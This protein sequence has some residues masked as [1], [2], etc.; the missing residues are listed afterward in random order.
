MADLDAEQFQQVDKVRQQLL[1]VI[2]R[3]GYRQVDTPIVEPT[4]LF[5]RK[6]GGERVAQMYAFHYRE[7][8]IALRPEHTAS[9]LRM[10]VDSMQSQPLPLRLCYAGPVFRYEKPQASRTRQ[11][12][13][14]GCELLGASGP[15]ADAEVIHL[16]LDGLASVGVSGVLVLGHVGL[17]LE[18]LERLPLRHRARDWLLWSMERLRKGRPVDLET[19]IA[20]LTSGDRLA[21]LFD[22]MS[23]ALGQ[24]PSEQLEG[25]VLAVLNEVGVQT[26]GGSRTPQEIVAGVVDKMNSH[27]DEGHVRQAFEFV[28]QLAGLRGAPEYV[29]PELRALVRAHDL[30]EEPIERI[31]QVLEI[32]AIYGH[33]TSQIELSPGL[34]RGLHYYTGMLFEIYADGS[35]QVQLCGGGRYDDLAQTLGSRQPLEASGFTYGLER[36]AEVAELPDAPHTARTL[37]VPA[38]DRAHASAIRAAE[39]MRARGEVVELDVRGRSVAAS[40]RFAQRN[41]INALLVVDHDGKSILERFDD[42]EHSETVRTVIDG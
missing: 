6:S 27:S 37:V 3:H 4:E 17:V 19:E 20:G 1:N 7:R 42:V 5:L 8:D 32:L 25:W 26:E 15:L 24:V 40:R 35:Q 12:T 39:G 38:D 11:F 28:E 9:I 22:Q 30:N 34:G 2:R 10:Y 36:I 14:V 41:G 23:G 13:E 33:D 18:Y 29:L 16:A 31:E 21:D